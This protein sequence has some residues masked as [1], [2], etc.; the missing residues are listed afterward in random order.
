MSEFHLIESLDSRDFI[1]IKKFNVYNFFIIMGINGIIH[2]IFVD[3]SVFQ[4]K[5]RIFFANLNLMENTK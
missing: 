1:F 3:W 4:K 5:G 2:G